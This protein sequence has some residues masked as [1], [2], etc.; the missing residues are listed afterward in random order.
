MSSLRFV[1]DDKDAVNNYRFYNIPDK[2]QVLRVG[3]GMNPSKAYMDLKGIT[4]GS[5]HNC[6]RMEIIKGTC[7]PVI[8]DFYKIDFSDYAEYC[9]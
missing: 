4:V 9:R 8:F 2:G 7:T 1:P 3:A 5:S 6:K